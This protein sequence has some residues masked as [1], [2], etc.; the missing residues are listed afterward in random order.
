MDVSIFLC[1]TDERASSSPRALPCFG[2]LIDPF[3][4]YRFQEPL[5]QWSRQAVHGIEIERGVFDDA[6]A[7]LVL[8]G[9]GKFRRNNLL[10]IN[11]FHLLYT[12]IETF[13]SCSQHTSSPHLVL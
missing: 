4:A 12:H 1:I 10:R 11:L 9:L 2:Q 3:G 7:W 13:N 5:H 8:L 6:W